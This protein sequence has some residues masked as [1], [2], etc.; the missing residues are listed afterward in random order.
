MQLM[1][2][3]VDQIKPNP[4]NARIHS[5]KQIHQISESIRAFGF[6]NP[7]LID[8]T[9]TVIAGNGRL[10]AATLLKMSEV[11][12]IEITGLSSHQMRALALAD[13]R[14]ALNAGWDLE[15]LASE[16]THISSL[17]LDF[18]VEVTGFETAEID[19]LLDPHDAERVNGID[20]SLMISA[21]NV[22]QPGD[23]SI[24]T[25]TNCSV[26]TLLIHQW[27]LKSWTATKPEWASPI[28]PTTFPSM[29]MSAVQVQSSTV[30]S[31][32]P[33]AK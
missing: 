24:L 33:W 5:K 18:D 30:S 13:N 20:K 8:E 26:A 28:H 4:T 32:W 21:R 15:I 10:A 19:L 27:S 6:R 17:E 31:R 22:T 29:A 16:L 3:P 25:T 2:K 14:I 12:V 11:P 1:M 9:S 7:I 23:L